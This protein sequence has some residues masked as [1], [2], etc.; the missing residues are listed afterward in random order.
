MLLCFFD[1]SSAPHP[2]LSF[3]F[4]PLAILDRSWLFLPRSFNRIGGSD[5]LFRVR[6]F[7]GLIPVVAF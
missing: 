3:N 4:F 6:S 7:S 1:D 5:Y 2:S